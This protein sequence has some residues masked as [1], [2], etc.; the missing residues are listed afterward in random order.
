MEYLY[1][2]NVQKEIY[3]DF[4]QQPPAAGYQKSGEEAC[5]LGGIGNRINIWSRYW[6]LSSERTIECIFLAAYVMLHF[7]DI[8]LISHATTTTEPYKRS[9]NTV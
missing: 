5:Q 1:K 7:K 3:K 8:L 9:R 4:F 6:W 2:E